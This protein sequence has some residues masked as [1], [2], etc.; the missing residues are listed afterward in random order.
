MKFA[1]ALAVLATVALA[2]AANAGDEPRLK[3]C[4]Q[5]QKQVAAALETAQPGSTTDTA[6]QEATNGRNYCGMQLYA[7]GV[8]HY[9]KAL[10]LL[11]KG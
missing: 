8:S 11:G 2:Q 5:L 6:R 1:Y 7:V 10:Q 3:D 4:N 9:T